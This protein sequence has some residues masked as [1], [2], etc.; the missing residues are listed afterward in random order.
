MWLR[1][2]MAAAGARTVTRMPF[3]MADKGGIRDGT[4]SALFASV[5]RRGGPPRFFRMRGACPRWRGLSRLP[6]LQ[7]QFL[8]CLPPL[9]GLGV[10]EKLRCQAFDQPSGATRHL[11]PTARRRHAFDTPGLRSVVV[12][13]YIIILVN[14]RPLV[15]GVCST[16][17]GSPSQRRLRDSCPSRGGPRKRRMLLCL[18]AGLFYCPADTD[19]SVP[20]GWI[21]G[22][23][24]KERHE[25]A[26]KGSGGRRAYGAVP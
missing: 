19:Q 3:D 14:H 16:K 18:C 21:N 12:G 11:T 15:G 7:R 13:A 24:R 22:R 26:R 2:P 20:N 1:R 9:A 23:S 25:E 8:R 5:P 4:G 10:V 6:D 17:F